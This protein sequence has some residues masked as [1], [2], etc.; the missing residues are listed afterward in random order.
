M[1][2]VAASAA[3]KMAVERYHIG[4]RIVDIEA[5]KKRYE[6]LRSGIQYQ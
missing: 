6:A 4:H 3:K 1:G 2:V 5:V